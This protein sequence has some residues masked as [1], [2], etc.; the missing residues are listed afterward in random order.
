MTAPSQKLIWLAEN[1]GINGRTKTV[2]QIK[3]EHDA[4]RHPE[5][6][7]QF[8]MRLE[9][10]IT[11]ELKKTTCWNCHE[12]YSFYE[13]SCPD[14]GATNANRDLEMSQNGRKIGTVN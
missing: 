6:A 11:K 9:E 4:N 12:Q 14:C 3:A 10:Q 13:E 7:D 5:F 1:C 8:D 2:E